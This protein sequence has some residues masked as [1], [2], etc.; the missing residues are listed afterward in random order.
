MRTGGGV[1]MV[2]AV[3]GS[4]VLAVPPAAHATG[5]ALA[6]TYD[7][8]GPSS[9][10]DTWT[11]TPQCSEVSIG[12]ES[13]VHSPLIDGQAFYRG[14][15]TWVMTL[16]GLVPVCPDKTNAKGAMIYQWDAVSLEGQLTAVQR[17]VC[18]MTRPGQSQIAFRLVKAAG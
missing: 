13:D 6:G 18:Q 8:V 5:T 9:L 17:G 11:I 1:A 12:C 10:L 4:L 15:N 14:G 3:V 16:T 7:V 2:G